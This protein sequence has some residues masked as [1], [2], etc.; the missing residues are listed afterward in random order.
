L[1]E[2][3]EN[4]KKGWSQVKD[5]LGCYDDVVDKFA[6]NP[7]LE[8]AYEAWDKSG[9][10]TIVKGEGED[11]FTWAYDMDLCKALMEECNKVDGM[12][13]TPIP[14]ETYECEYY[15]FGNGDGKPTVA[16]SGN[17]VCLADSDSC[18]ALEGGPVAVAD[19]EMYDDLENIGGF[20]C[21]SLVSVSGASTNFL[22]SVVGAASTVVAVTVLLI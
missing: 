5:G 18:N 7:D 14:D 9:T 16:T 17:G 1:F 11:S 13:F 8:A 15:G 3:I 21:K 12:T 20:I 6:E 10:K 19:G 4:I 22:G 2:I